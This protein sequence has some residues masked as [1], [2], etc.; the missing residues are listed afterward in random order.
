MFSV[1]DSKD[2]WLDPSIYGAR[3][4]AYT[5]S[6]SDSWFAP[7]GLQ[8]GRLTKPTEVE[9]KLNQGDRDSLHSGGNI[10]NPIVAF[11]QQGIT[12][13]GQRTTQRSPTALDRINIRRLMI[14]VRKVI[15]AATRRFV[16]EPNDEFTWAQIEGVIKLFCTA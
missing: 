6:V 9:V 1:F 12:I 13:F 16:F 8:R 7:A 4:M 10:I 5:D 11:P 2:I 3:Q 15:L 14:Y